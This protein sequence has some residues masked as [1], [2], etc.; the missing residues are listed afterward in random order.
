MDRGYRVDHRA[1]ARPHISGATHGGLRTS[2]R[3]LAQVLAAAVGPGVT[4]NYDQLSIAG[5]EST[6]LLLGIF[7]VSILHNL[8]HLGFGVAGLAL[9]RSAHGARLFLLGGGVIY[10][11]VWLHGLLIDHDSAANVVPINT[12]DNWLHMVLGVGMIMLG[13]LVTDRLG[14]R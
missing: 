7:Q 2:Q 9:A 6:A 13:A 10:L 12:A 3:N 11:A 8:V 1:R 14:A 4:T 5:R